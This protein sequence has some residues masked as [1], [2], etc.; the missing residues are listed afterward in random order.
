LLR[1]R[2]NKDGKQLVTSLIDEAKEYAGS[3]PTDDMAAVLLEV[4]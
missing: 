3:S 4:L 1:K 2:G